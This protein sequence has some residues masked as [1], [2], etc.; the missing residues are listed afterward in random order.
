[1]AKI[2]NETLVSDKNYGYPDL[3][4]EDTNV[5]IALD[6]E[7]DEAVLL[8]KILTPRQYVRVALDL[9]PHVDQDFDVDFGKNVGVTWNLGEAA[10]SRQKVSQG[11][12]KVDANELHEANIQADFFA[13]SIIIMYNRL[14]SLDRLDLDQGGKLV[15]AKALIDAYDLA[16]GSK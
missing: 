2:L 5:L 11:L 14:T 6:S 9:D 13:K 12:G 1:M 15:G 8:L 3:S 7:G 4:R 10:N 16:H